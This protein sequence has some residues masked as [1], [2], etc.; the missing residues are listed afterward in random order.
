MTI[1]NYHAYDTV[2]AEVIGQLEAGDLDSA[3]NHLHEKQLLVVMVKE[4]KPPI[5]GLEFLMPR[6][7]SAEELHHLTTELALLLQSGVKIDRGLA[8]LRRNSTSQAQGKLVS[9]LHDSVRRG[10]PLSSALAAQPN[11]F[12]PLYVNLVKLGEASGNLSEVFKKLAIDIKFQEE[13]KR[14]VSQALLYP[15]IIMMVC[16]LCLVF[17]FNYIVP[18]MRSLFDGMIEVPL[19]TQALLGISDWMVHYQW[20]LLLAVFVLVG[21]T[22][23]LQKTATG[24]RKIHEICSR[25][26]LVRG[27]LVLVEKIRFN[28]AVAMMLESGVL[29]DRS[30]VMAIGNVKNQVL[31]QGLIAA[32]ERIKKGESLASSLRV[33]PLYDDF[34][35]SLI[36]VGEETGDLGLVFDEISNRCRNEFS[37]WV[38]R[39][40]A[41]LEPLL[42]LFMGGVV[43]GIVV[44]MLLSIVSVNE[45]G[46]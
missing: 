7:I 5:A 17:I 3:L 2:G 20:F 38:E 16:V 22:S 34:T 46:F 9:Y 25:L 14:K 45:I 26:P 41:L 6:D 1:F 12:N 40:T 11:V 36:E 33:S 43:G 39:F 27:V 15:T 19:Y 31:R 44:V 24:S 8:I 30:I 37:S 23:V 35:I 18:Q 10:E 32:K 13:L 28:S 42:I 4:R 29:I 21:A